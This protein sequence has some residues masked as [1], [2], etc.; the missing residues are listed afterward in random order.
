MFFRVFFQFFQYFS[1]ELLAILLVAKK[2]VVKLNQPCFAS[3]ALKSNSTSFLI[4]FNELL[5]LKFFGR[6]KLVNKFRSRG[7]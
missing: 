1:K 6:S 7:F 5:K 2:Y 4:D 3:H